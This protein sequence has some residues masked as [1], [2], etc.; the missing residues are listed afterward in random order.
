M[1]NQFSLLLL[2]ISYPSIRSL[3]NLSEKTSYKTSTFNSFLKL[4]SKPRKRDF[5]GVVSEK[6]SD[7]VW[8]FGKCPAHRQNRSV[9]LKGLARAHENTEMKCR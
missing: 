6:H 3:Y 8:I 5:Y 1:L 2:V 9:M 7:L 4:K